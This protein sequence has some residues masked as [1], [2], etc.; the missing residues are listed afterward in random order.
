[1]YFQYSLIALHQI[2][3]QF[4]SGGNAFSLM[5]FFITSAVLGP[6]PPV[7]SS[8]V[9]PAFCRYY[10]FP[11]VFFFQYFRRKILFNYILHLK[12]LGVNNNRSCE[13]NQTYR[14]YQKEILFFGG[15]GGGNGGGRGE[16]SL[17]KSKNLRK[18][19]KGIVA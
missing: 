15:G 5:Y 18:F 19:L 2:S 1:M 14:C 7:I 9:S 17:Q 8:P 10:F 4:F 11:N 12:I 6:P 13:K 16:R 3:L